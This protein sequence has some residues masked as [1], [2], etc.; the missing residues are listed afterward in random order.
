VYG[1]KGDFE[2][3]FE[4]I[5][6][7]LREKKRIGNNRG[8]LWSYYRLAHIYRNA[9]DYETALD[10]F[11]RCIQQGWKPWRSM[12]NIFLE[13]GNYDSSIYYFQKGLQDYHTMV[14]HWPDLENYLCCERSM[15]LPYLT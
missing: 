11:R 7:G 9:G 12:G 1:A 4:Y 5:K 3:Q 10:Y 6:K 15:T 8:M 14:L 13:M 2:K